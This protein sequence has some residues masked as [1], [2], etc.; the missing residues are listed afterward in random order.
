MAKV[1]PVLDTAKPT[2]G[3]ALWLAIYAPDVFAHAFKKATAANV[4]RKIKTS[5]GRLADDGDDLDFS[6]DSTDVDTG[7]VSATDFSTAG[8]TAT[9][10]DLLFG[11]SAPETAAGADSVLGINT[12]FTTAGGATTA[13]DFSGAGLDAITLNDGDTLANL[14]P[15]LVTDQTPAGSTVLQAA[16]TAPTSSGTT[17]GSLLASAATTVLQGI[18]AVGAALTTPKALQALAQTATAYYNAQGNATQAQLLATQIALAAAGKPVAP[19]TYT[20]DPATGQQ[21]P[22]LAT[23]AANGQV[24]YTPLSSAQLAQLQA[25]GV[26]SGS[27]LGVWIAAGAAVVLLVILAT[28]NGSDSE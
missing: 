22:A 13:T 25:A 20:T 1:V 28:R 16:A 2:N 27:K 23:T 11:T 21:V 12:D 10:D 6:D 19:I 4:A 26:S 24:Q 14:D 8:A 15:T 7:S 18:G 5:V 17:V 3:L 9:P